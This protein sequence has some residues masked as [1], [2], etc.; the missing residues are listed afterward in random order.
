MTVN[1]PICLAHEGLSNRWGE[2]EKRFFEDD[3]PRRPMPVRLIG[4]TTGREQFE[5]ERD[6]KKSYKPG[7]VVGSNNQKPATLSTVPTRNAGST[8]RQRVGKELSWTGPEADRNLRRASR[9]CRNVCLCWLHKLD[10]ETVVPVMYPSTIFSAPWYLRNTH[11][12][13]PRSST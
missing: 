5:G 9:L 1:L 12:S 7:W 4:I 13:V 11:N 8:A 6:K 10:S 3:E 2:K